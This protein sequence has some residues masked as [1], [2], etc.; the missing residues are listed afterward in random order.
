MHDRRQALS[1]RILKT[2]RGS[3]M[4]VC[5]EKEKEEE[6]LMWNPAAGPW[7]EPDVK[8]VTVQANSME[9]LANK[10]REID[11]DAV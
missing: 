2:E 8:K 1:H 7:K 3:R 10:I 11:W 4:D 6:R 9:E 5:A